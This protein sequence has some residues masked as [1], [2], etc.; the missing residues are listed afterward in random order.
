MEMALTSGQIY[1]NLH[2][3]DVK[4]SMAFFAGLGFEFGMRFTNEE[5]AACLIVGEKHL[6][7]VAAGRVPED[8]HETDNHRH[9]QVRAAHDRDHGGEPGAC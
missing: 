6:R 8:V 7:D 3:K 1:V 4:R 5:Q 9:G 2:V